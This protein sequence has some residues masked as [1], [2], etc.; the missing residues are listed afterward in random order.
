VAECDLF[1]A[2]KDAHLIGPPVMVFTTATS[3]S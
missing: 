1:S 2:E 3:P